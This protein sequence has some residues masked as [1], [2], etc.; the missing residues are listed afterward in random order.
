M[1]LLPNGSV[2]NTPPTSCSFMYKPLNDSLG[3]PSSISNTRRVRYDLPIYIVLANNTPTYHI[4]VA[5]SSDS[6]FAMA[7]GG[8]RSFAATS[9]C[10][11]LTVTTVCGIGVL[12]LQITCPPSSTPTQAQNVLAHESVYAQ[13]VP[14]LLAT[15]QRLS[16]D[17][18]SSDCWGPICTHASAMVVGQKAK[19]DF[20]IYDW[21][22]RA[23]GVRVVH[24]KTGVIEVYNGNQEISLRGIGAILCHSI[25]TDNCFRP[26]E[27]AVAYPRKNF[28]IFMRLGEGRKI[29]RVSHAHGVGYEHARCSLLHSLDFY[30]HRIRPLRTTLRARESRVA[31]YIAHTVP[32]TL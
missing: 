22:F 6:L 7:R 14:S 11:L 32:S 16:R 19:R 13:L 5:C 8:A 18:N 10:R 20:G 17:W 23:H 3:Y 31:P 26:A 24:P 28:Q 25:F 9:S 27:P 30:G 29:N 4:P 1:G 15:E 2:F 21:A 12:L